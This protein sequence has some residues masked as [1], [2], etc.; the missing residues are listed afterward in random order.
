MTFKMKKT[1][2]IT[3]ASSGIGEATARHFA[4]QGWNVAATMRRVTTDHPL[5]KI[6]N[7]RIYELDVSDTSSIKT[8][9]DSAIK[10]FRKIDV[11]FNNAGYSLAGPFEAFT[12]EEV[13]SQFNT[14]VFGVMNVTRAILPYFRD[15]M[16]GKILN[17]TSS[18]GIITFPLYSLY[19]ST[20][21]AIEG[22]MESLQ[23]EV[24]PFNIY[25]KNIEPATV[26][27][28]FTNNI[29]FTSHAAYDTYAHKV[30]SNTLKGYQN[31]PTP[32]V[33]AKVVFR[34]ANDRNYTLRYP[35]TPQAGFIFFL[36][37]IL[38]FKWYNA[39]IS[40]SMEKDI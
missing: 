4:N 7:I 3:G 20:K 30:Q 21:W 33:V 11:V 2:F 14:N 19:N 34:A 36:R 22:F 40:S 16:G 8:A 5:L 26:K 37:R 15:Q 6:A 38:P 1:I 27:S 32:D 31:A 10:D 13:Q 24:K 12:P 25:I 17:T 23:F 35:G 39:M 28:E 18:G 9:I 29:I